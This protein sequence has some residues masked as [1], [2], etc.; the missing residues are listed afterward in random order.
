MS[1][2]QEPQPV[3]ADTKNWVA[4]L[5]KGCEQCGW[6]PFEPRETAARLSDAALRW[7]GVLEGD[8]VSMRP[9]PLV[10]SPVEYAC[11]VRDL[12]QLLADRVEAI[13]SEDDP[14]FANYDGDAAA[15]EQRTWASDPLV[16][17]REIA[18]ATQR[19]VAELKA[20]GA[21]DW[22]R[23]GHRGDGVSFTLGSLCQFKV[24]EAE[25]HLWDVEV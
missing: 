10:W 3:P 16:V 8:D 21:D 25:H 6:Q 9:D 13:L 19:A 1:E 11:H 18:E 14:E 22:Q 15:V 2:T 12:L 23:P 5:D 20:V 17:S 7:E 4:V 24:H